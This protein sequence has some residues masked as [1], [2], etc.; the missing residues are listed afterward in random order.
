[1]YLAAMLKR[2]RRFQSA[3]DAG[4]G[5]SAGRSSCDGRRL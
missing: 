5:E 2:A 4:C 1:V 3:L